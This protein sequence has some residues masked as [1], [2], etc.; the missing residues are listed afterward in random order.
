MSEIEMLRE[1]INALEKWTQNEIKYLLARIALLES[2]K[3]VNA[4]LE[5]LAECTS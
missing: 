3:P 2:K 1:Q 4:N 5:P